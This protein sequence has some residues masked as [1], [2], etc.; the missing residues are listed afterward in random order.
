MSDQE[1]AGTGGGFVPY[2]PPESKIPEL[3]LKAIVLGVLLAILMAAA[4]A[5]L[6]LYVGMTVS[7]T[8]PAAVIAIAIFRVFKG[9][10][11]ETNLSKTT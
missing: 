7:A 6:G 8:I 2:I 9:T 11:L 3:T 5:Y 1:S 4:N 10:I